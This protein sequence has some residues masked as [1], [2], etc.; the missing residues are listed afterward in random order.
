MQLLCYVSRYLPKD[1]SQ[2]RRRI[3][4][5][6]L[7]VM[8]EGEVT[9]KMCAEAEDEFVASAE[10]NT[11]QLWN[12]IAMGGADLEEGIWIGSKFTTS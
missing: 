11:L 9:Y 6:P 7:G 10:G 12:G 8:M 3:D 1:E 2:P 4:A 5:D